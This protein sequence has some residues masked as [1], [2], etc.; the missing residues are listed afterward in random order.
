MLVHKDESAALSAGSPTASSSEPRGERTG[1]RVQL[2]WRPAEGPQRISM[3]ARDPPVLHVGPQ[4]RRSHKHPRAAQTR[5]P[6]EPQCCI[7]KV[8]GRDPWD[9]LSP[10][11][12]LARS[13]EVNTA[14]SPSRSYRQEDHL[15]CI[16]L[17]SRLT[18]SRAAVCPRL[19]CDILAKQLC[20]TL[21]IPP[22]HSECCAARVDSN[23][24]GIH[25]L[26]IFE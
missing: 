8:L 20:P 3:V 11:L 6:D 10:A 23:E 17:S 25:M 18:H 5:V 19:S 24:R 1:F 26:C 12:C 16:H 9:L 7:T 14:T 2:H 4:A 15:I 22:L 21:F 13:R